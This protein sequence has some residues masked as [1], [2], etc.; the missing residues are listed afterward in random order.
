MVIAPSSYA[1]LALNFIFKFLNTKQFKIIA[2]VL[3]A[4]SGESWCISIKR[5]AC[6]GWGQLQVF[7]FPSSRA[8][9]LVG[10]P[11]RDVETFVYGPEERGARSVIAVVDERSLLQ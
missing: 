8:P 6:H 1:R 10:G 5:K 2:T 4:F 11:T 7:I 3:K 9:P